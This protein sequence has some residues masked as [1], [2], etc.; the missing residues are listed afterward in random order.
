MEN[1]ILPIS[2]SKVNDR[3]DNIIDGYWKLDS[4]N[5][6]KAKPH[7]I[8]LLQNIPNSSGFICVR[9]SEITDSDIV[10][11]LYNVGSRNVRIYLLVDK[12]SDSIAHIPNSLLR[13]SKGTIGS[14]IL[15]HPDKLSSNGLF[16]SDSFTESSFSDDSRNRFFR[17]MYNE[18]IKDIYL[19]FCYCFWMLPTE[20][21]I[22]GIK[23][24]VLSSPFDIYN[25]EESINGENYIYSKLFT[26][27]NNIPV[28][29]LIHQRIIA[30]GNETG[31][32]VTIEQRNKRDLGNI[33]ATELLPKNELE[34]IEPDI[35]TD[36]TAFYAEEELH[37]TIVPFT[38]PNNSQKSKL[39]DRWIS[40]NEEIK[41]FIQADITRIETEF[42]Q[43]SLYDYIKSLF[44][45][46]RD[47][48]NSEIERLQGFIDID[49]SQIPEMSIEYNLK[50]IN[51]AHDR[52]LASLNELKNEKDKSSLD[53]KID[54][55]KITLLELKE[56]LVKKE[57]EKDQ[58]NKMYEAAKH[59]SKHINPE[60][61]ILHE[62]LN[63]NEE[64]QIEEESPQVELLFDR[65]EI[66]KLRDNNAKELYDVKKSIKD[67]EKEIQNIQKIRDSFVPT[68][69][70]EVKGVSINFKELPLL[71]RKGELYEAS[72]KL[73][74][75]IKT[76]DDYDKAKAE[77]E[78]LN[79]K[80]CA[81][82]N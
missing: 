58:L 6:D 17:L 47:L 63:N 75:A 76:W 45:S 23:H 35:N 77:A 9:S 29:Q 61:D 22:D 69:I 68:K 72:G 70:A 16:F 15:I 14:Y 62:D 7:I 37:W 44:S 38:L 11:E 74:L 66:K 34:Q 19:H 57:A 41:K 67:L 8:K 50:Y 49:F 27:I 48:L 81:T 12:Y 20:E 3:R 36:N 24:D 60:T 78:R 25:P 59:P 10:R 82:S 65:K 80:L 54:T 1:L 55:L 40:K 30:M 21:F 51:E 39:Y 26:K 79:A 33:A 31:I 13:I 43:E 73:Y 18:K 5:L 4:I 64:V 52:I 46:K 71:P 53:V 32:P 2:R 28:G 42:A 56:L